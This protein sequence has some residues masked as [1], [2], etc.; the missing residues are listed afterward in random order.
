M[1][2]QMRTYIV[3]FGDDRQRDMLVKFDERETLRENLSRIV[4]RAIEQTVLPDSCS[5]GLVNVVHDGNELNLDLQASEQGVREYDILILHDLSQAIRLTIRAK[6]DKADPIVES[7]TVRP[8]Q[9]VREAVAPFTDRIFGE[10]RF[11]GRKVR[12]FNLVS[13]RKKIALDKTPLGQGL[14]GSIDA[15]LR[16][17]VRFEWPPGLFWPPGPYTTYLIGALITLFVAA[18]LLGDY[19]RK[20]KTY[21]VRFG[22]E[23][24]YVAEVIVDG[25]VIEISKDSSQAI[26][27]GEYRCH[28][29]FR[30]YPI[31]D[32]SI[33]VKPLNPFRDGIDISFQPV[34]E[35]EPRRARI[36]RFDFN[37]TN[38][39]SLD[40][41]KDK[42]IAV[43]INSFIH[44]PTD[45][46]GNFETSL[47]PGRYEIRYSG[48]D[49]DRIR[50]IE[51]GGVTI[52]ESGDA[53][54]PGLA[55]RSPD[56]TVFVLD[57]TEDLF[58]TE[59]LVLK[60]VY[61]MET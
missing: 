40:D 55:G 26:G 20:T 48:I 2:T 5:P 60:Y 57:L 45:A 32:T 9:P 52:F 21:A 30:G 31:R 39:R 49:D 61:E 42:S 19:H 44:E 59:P 47:Y 28:V 24:P 56:S 15:D 27:W 23:H 6:P 12:R 1:Q 13:G 58:E 4:P 25:D 38:R 36:C 11:Y 53:D 35:G 43:K 46:F 17:R 41:P 3:R 34:C 51:I 37:K 54:T 33:V 22:G 29:F 16:P 14:R 10:H 7:V 18:A 8:D 50:I